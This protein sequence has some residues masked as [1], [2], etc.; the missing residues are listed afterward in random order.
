MTTI[1]T[2]S[3]YGVISTLNSTTSATPLLSTNTSVFGS[4]ELVKNYTAASILLKLT[5]ASTSGYCNILIDSSNDNIG[6]IVSTETHSYINYTTSA[7]TTTIQFKPQGAFCR[8]RVYNGGTGTVSFE[9]QTRFNNSNDPDNT[10]GVISSANSFNFTSSPTLPFNGTFEDISQTSLITFLIN[11]T[12]TAP[13][14]AVSLTLEGIFSSDGI[15]DDRIVSYVTQDAT[16]NGSASATTSLTFNPAHTLLPIAKY[17]RVRVTLLTGTAA[18]LR[19]TAT[20][21][22]NKSKPLTSRVT[23]NLTDQF[24]SDTARSILVGRTLGTLLPQGHY[25]NIGVQNQSIATYIR[26]PASAF[27]EVLTAQL[28]PLIQYDFSN[29]EPYEVILPI[30]RNEST[31]SSYTYSNAF[32]NLT[33]GTSPA[34]TATN[35]Y[36]LSQ[37]AEFT[38]YKA[39]EGIDMRMTA[40]FDAAQPTSGCDQYVGLY[41]PENSFTFGYFT[42]TGTNYGFGIRYGTGGQEQI[43]FISVAGTSTATG[44]ISLNFGGTTVT[45]ASLPSG[46]TNVA[47]A[48]AITNAIIATTNLNTFGWT[49]IYYAS[50]S[51]PGIPYVVQ[52]VRRVASA[53][54]IAVSTISA[55]TGYTI[56]YPTGRSAVST[57][58]QYITQN[59]WNID[60]CADQGSLQQNYLYNPSG[61]QLDPTRGNI[62]R[63]TMQYLG[64]G[65]IT[66]YVENPATGSFIPVH[67][68]QYANSSTSTS[69]LSPNFRLTY[70]VEN[71]TNGSTITLKAASASCFTQGAVV[72]APLYRS[73]SYSILLNTLGSISKENSRVIFG[74]RVLR[75]KTST[76]SDLSTSLTINRSNLF[77][78]SISAAI[79][80]SGGGTNRANITFQLV[81]N[82]TQLYVGAP[83]A[84]TVYNPTW[85]V[86]EKDSTIIVFD[87]SVTTSTGT[88]VGYT[89]GLNVFDLPLVE[90]TASTFDMRNMLVNA[91]ADDIYLMTYYGETSGLSSFDVLGAISYQINN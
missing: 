11:G 85:R 28:T 55:P 3:N 13:P 49:A 84:A 37:S 31:K 14:A 87:G 38:K 44:T 6:S 8:I 4:Y 9:L 60:R 80:T 15:N 27:G 16:A 74:F 72:P 63:I 39:G 10:Y 26:D 89:G 50:S 88:G 69:V 79:N 25:Q 82:P 21:H 34:G 12:S 18:T 53:P 76:N 52:A 57:T 54:N 75:T 67:Q 45:T 59:T 32:L 17:F 22:T 66:F 20:Y 48:A 71:T 70:G 40:V 61:F 73:Y 33:V 7:S 24:D 83:A 30:V 86:Y 78:N 43:V 77:F 68:I 81:K 64:F 58:Y 19:F 51:A 62:Y 91:S 29:G 36:I 23:Q 41:T 56:T 1:Y 2:G 65:A 35:S 5:G 90:N 42:S 47:A 46:S